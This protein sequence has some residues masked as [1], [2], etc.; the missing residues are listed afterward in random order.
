ME[1][2]VSINEIHIGRTSSFLH[3]LFH[4]DTG[5]GLGATHKTGWTALVTR[6]I[7]DLAGDLTVHV[8]SPREPV[9]AATKLHAF[10]L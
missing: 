2:A 5:R 1:A 3:Q 4:G 7:E 8:A 9:P 10:A 6:C